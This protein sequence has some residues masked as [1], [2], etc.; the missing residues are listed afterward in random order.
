MVRDG[1]EL[2]IYNIDKGKEKL[3]IV[4]V[5]IV[6]IL[7]FILLLLILVI[8]NSVNII[9]ANSVYKQYASQLDSLN[10]QKEQ[11]LAKKEAERLAKI[12]KL[13]DEGKKNIEGIYKSDKKRA[14]LTFDD[15]SILYY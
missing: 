15:R 8:K 2:D 13:T 7:V 10:Y 5:L 3:N 11:E 14:F 12:P 4:K 9:K 1:Y 6:V